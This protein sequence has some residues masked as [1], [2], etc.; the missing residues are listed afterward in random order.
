MKGVGGG[1]TAGIWRRQTADARREGYCSGE[2]RFSFGTVNNSPCLSWTA[3][4]AP[5]VRSD[6][7]GSPKRGADPRGLGFQGF[8]WHGKGRALGQYEYEA[9]GNKAWAGQREPANMHSWL[10][11]PAQIPHKQ[12]CSV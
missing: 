8:H 5:F 9:A 12:T 11:I 3:F 2:Q 10:F 7:L 1:T 6:I 4:T